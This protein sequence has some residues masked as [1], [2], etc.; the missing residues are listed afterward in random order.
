MR[1]VRL[2]ELT[3]YV[4]PGVEGAN[5]VLMEKRDEL[6]QIVAVCGY[7]IVGIVPFIG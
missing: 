2:C 7:G 1:A 4:R 6:V 3:I 5:R